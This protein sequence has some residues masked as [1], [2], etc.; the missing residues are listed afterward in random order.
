MIYH[1][2]KAKAADPV[3]RLVRH[4]GSVRAG[5]DYASVA[6]NKLPGNMDSGF[7]RKI[8]RA[9]VELHIFFVQYQSSFHAAGNNRRVTPFAGATAE[10]YGVV[11]CEVQIGIGGEEA[12][13]LKQL[14]KAA[15]IVS[16]NVAM[17]ALLNLKD[18]D[19]H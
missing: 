11:P 16:E 10:N 14:R 5:D 15:D 13:R 2:N 19:G 3:H 17:L 9:S 18:V 7:E 8:L 6:R 4:S 1:F 12:E